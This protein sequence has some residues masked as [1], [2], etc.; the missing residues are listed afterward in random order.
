MEKYLT[1]DIGG[2]NIK[3]AV[4]TESLECLEKREIPTPALPPS[5]HQL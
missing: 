5:Y 3:Y 4:I 2:T 1:I